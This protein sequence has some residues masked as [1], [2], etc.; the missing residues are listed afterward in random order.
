ML[1]LR[2]S[3]SDRTG[4]GYGFS[5]F[6][7]ASTSIIVFVLPSNNVEIENNDIKTDL[8]IENIDKGKSIL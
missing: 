2:K 7:I 5:S 1:S 4:L 8:T 6:N 3:T